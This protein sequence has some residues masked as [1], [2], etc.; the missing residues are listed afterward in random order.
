MLDIDRGVDVDAAGKQ[1][2]DVEIALWMA[3]TRRVG[4]GKFIDQR[5]LRMAR[6]QRVEIHLLDQLIPVL[7]PPARNNFQAVQQRFGLQPVRG[8][9]PTP[10]TTSAPAFSFA[11]AFSSIA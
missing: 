7:E 6:D 9:R 11:R 8:S 5:D 2:L 10:T 3:A 1:L 4:V